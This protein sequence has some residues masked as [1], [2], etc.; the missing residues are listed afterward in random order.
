MAT[1]TQ[2]FGGSTP[3]VIFD[4]ILNHTPPVM[5][6]LNPLVPPRLEGIIST[7]LEKDR[8]MRYQHASDLQAELKRLKR[9]LDSGT[10]MG[11]GVVSRTG[12][13]TAPATQRRPTT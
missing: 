2:A 11:E 5:L 7:L 8:E 9:D 10:M 3:A 6:N 4:A 13:G 1:G 12:V